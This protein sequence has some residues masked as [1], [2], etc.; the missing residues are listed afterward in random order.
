[1]GADSPSKNTPNP[2]K[3]SAQNVC[4]S[5]KKSR[6]SMAI[7]FFFNTWLNLNPKVLMWNLLLM[8]AK[9]LIWRLCLFHLWLAI[10]YELLFALFPKYIPI[11]L[12]CKRSRCANFPRTAILPGETK[13]KTKRKKSTLYCGRWQSLAFM[14]RC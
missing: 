6:T 10:P 2:S 4:P 14:H 1:M 3:I 8:K 7:R 9:L 11:S 13:Q 5:P 12:L